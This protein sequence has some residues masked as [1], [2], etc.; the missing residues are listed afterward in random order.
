ML[1]DVLEEVRNKPW[2]A[3]LPSKVL[4]YLRSHRIPEDIITDLQASSYSDWIK[5][6]PLSLM[7]MPKM[8][9]QT[10]GL[11]PC[12]ENGYLVLAGGANGDPVAVHRDTRKMVFVSHD[13]LWDEEWK[14]FLECV[15][16]M[17]FVYEEFWQQVVADNDFPWDYYQAREKWLS[18]RTTDTDEA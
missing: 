16:E 4:K 6:G 8:I 10:T 11:K 14:D 5:I 7:P 15:Q 18:P 17:P 13:T 2:P 1:A 12:I 3:P 9:E